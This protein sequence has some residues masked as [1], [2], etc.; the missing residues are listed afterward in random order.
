MKREKIIKQLDWVRKEFGS[1]EEYIKIHYGKQAPFS[2]LGDVCLVH[3]D[4]PDEETVKER[5][6]EFLK[7][8]GLHD[9]CPLCQLEREEDGFVVYDGCDGWCPE[10]KQKET[11]E[12]YDPE[13][14]KEEKTEEIGSR[15]PNEAKGLPRS[16]WSSSFVNTDNLD[17]MSP[18]LA[19]QILS[20]GVL[21]HAIELKMDLE[22][23]DSA[24]DVIRSFVEPIESACNDLKLFLASES[25]SFVP[26]EI[27]VN[28][29]VAISALSQLAAREFREKAS[30][31]IVKLEKLLNLVERIETQPSF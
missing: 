2:I 6:R 23:H 26:N 3:L 4:S 16:P 10:C 14:W 20:L 5:E 27:P 7:D 24:E 8:D 12:N 21:A 29:Q 25:T 15:V 22:N 31:L 18:G 9:D 17:E 11:C 1:I 13:E 19:M 30:D 28:I